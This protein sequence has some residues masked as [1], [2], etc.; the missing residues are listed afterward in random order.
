MVLSS[1]QGQPFFQ[2]GHATGSAAVVNA[3]VL[4]LSELKLGSRSQIDTT[5]KS[6]HCSSWVHFL[7]IIFMA[8]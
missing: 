8:L 5:R 1:M 2:Q 7:E 4:R 6:Y 3:H